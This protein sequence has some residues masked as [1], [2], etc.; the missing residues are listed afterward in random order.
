MELCHSALAVVRSSKTGEPGAFLVESVLPGFR[1]W[2][3]NDSSAITFTPI[4]SNRERKILQWLSFNQH[5]QW[6]ETRGKLFLTDFQGLYN[7]H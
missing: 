7:A 5:I 4:M 6:L 2:M 3:R 1:H